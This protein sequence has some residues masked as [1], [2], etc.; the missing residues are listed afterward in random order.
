MADLKEKSCH[1]G[2][3]QRLKNRFLRN[4][5][6][7]FDN[8]ELLELLLFYAIPQGDTNPLAH[9]LIDHFGTLAGVFDASVSDLE[10][11]P[12]VGQHTALLIHMLPQI[13]RRYHVDR[14]A[15]G[16]VLRDTIDYAEWLRP[17]FFGARNEMAY[18]LCMNAK[19]KV[20]GCDLI[21]EGDLTSCAL[22][23]RQVAEIAMRYRASAVVLAHCHVVG[24]IQP[25]YAD[26]ETTLSCRKTL[27][28]LSITLV[29]HL[30][31]CD[32]EY[33]SLAQQGKLTRYFY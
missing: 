2:H 23:T 4:G 22:F 33:I 30:I 28:E 29:D 11:V 16:N 3:R 19:G 15:P 9:R 8:H 21:D 10:Q 12:G 26:H 20:L 18:L 6:A 5:E 27:D 31:F 17:Y 25:S 13:A 7:A 24:A 14:S 32:G 1:V